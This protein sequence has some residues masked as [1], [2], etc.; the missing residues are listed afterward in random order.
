M[1]IKLSNSFETIKQINKINLKT[2]YINLAAIC[3]QI[4]TTESPFIT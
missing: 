2:N 4:I 3:D 1:K